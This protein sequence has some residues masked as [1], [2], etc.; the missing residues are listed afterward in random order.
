MQMHA[1][2]WAIVAILAIPLLSGCGLSLAED[3]TPPPNYISPTDPP[4][5]T[6]TSSASQQA[7]FPLVPPDP[8][9]GAALYA[10]NCLPCH[11]ES[12]MGDGPQ[13]SKLPNPAAPIGSVELARNARPVDWYQIVTKGDLQKFMPGFSEKLNDRQR[14]DVVAYALML[15]APAEELEKGKIVYEQNCAECHGANGQGDGAQA[16]G[17]STKPAAW[18]QNQARLA[19]LSADEIIS[20]VCREN[21]G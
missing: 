20:I 6:P 15:S 7:V 5:E 17:S 12:G 1:R 21:S 16:A 14:W 4:L 9:Q 19:Q 13:A 3:V 10:E 18:N 8:A 11:G 2:A